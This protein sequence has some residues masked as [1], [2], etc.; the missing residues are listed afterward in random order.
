M[1]NL[2]KME[3]IILETPLNEVLSSVID[4]PTTINKGNKDCGVKADIHINS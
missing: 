3:H 2:E 1:K 4:L